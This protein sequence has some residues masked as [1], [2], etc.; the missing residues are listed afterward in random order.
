MDGWFGRE[1][2]NGPG[3]VPE[4][5]VVTEKRLNM[6]DLQLC[7]S[8]FMTFEY[9]NIHSCHTYRSVPSVIFHHQSKSAAVTECISPTLSPPLEQYQWFRP[10]IA[11]RCCCVAGSECWKTVST[12]SSAVLPWLVVFHRYCNSSASRLPATASCASAPPFLPHDAI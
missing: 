6:D 8:V 5:D 9:R 10:L 3:S 1:G 11:R 4:S 7:Y 12:P 2:C